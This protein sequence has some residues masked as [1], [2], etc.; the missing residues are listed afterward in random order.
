M[1][2]ILPNI[3]AGEKKS[4]AG[5]KVILW[6]KSECLWRKSEKRWR[7]YLIH[8]RLDRSAAC[9]HSSIPSESARRGVPRSTIFSASLTV[10]FPP[11]A[12]SSPRLLTAWTLEPRTAASR[13]PDDFEALTLFFARHDLVPIASSHY[14]LP[15]LPPAPTAGLVDEVV[16]SARGQPFQ[17][18]FMPSYIKLAKVPTRGLM[19][20]YR[21]VAAWHRRLGPLDATTAAIY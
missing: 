5:E 12:V 9:V 16:V 6:R 21:S 10:T 2:R 4:R 3:E 1:Q 18:R 20:V 7:K 13:S 17:S 19:S 15:R 8:C 14:L 11:T